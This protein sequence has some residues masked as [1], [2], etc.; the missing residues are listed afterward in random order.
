MMS[1][2]FAI[3]LERSILWACRL[4]V[5][6]EKP[7]N[8]HPQASF[9]DLTCGDFLRSAELIAPVL[10]R[11]SELGI[12]RGILSAV[13]ATRAAVGTN[14]NLGMI[15]L[16]APL[17]AV[18]QESTLKGGI[19]STLRDLSVQDAVDVFEGIRR[20]QPG[21]MGEVSEQDVS[22][23]PTVTLLEAMSLAAER[24]SIARQYA[25]DYS[26][27]F[28]GLEFLR[29]NVRDFS[30]DWNEEIVRLA[31]WLQ[32]G[33]PDSLILRK[34]GGAVADEGARRAGEV[35]KVWD[36]PIVRRSALADFDGWLRADGHQR[37]PGT[38]ADLTAAILFAAFRDRIFSL[39]ESWSNIPDLGLRQ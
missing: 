27:V 8:V 33:T 22:R 26:L 3:H 7:G 18:Q 20:A 21:G 30:R 19:S 39:P 25:T 24:D 10:A 38:T 14:T 32:A 16:I 37:N 2:E 11:T 35:L 34:C 23:R 36:D 29:Q 13:T 12:G 5:L 28:E 31:I 15:L 17:A 6:A 4:E 9:E 1:A